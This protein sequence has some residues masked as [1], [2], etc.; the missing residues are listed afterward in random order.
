MTRLLNASAVRT[1]PMATAMALLWLLATAAA[2]SPAAWALSCIAP[3]PMDEAVVQAEIA[4]VGTVTAV[5]NDAHLASISVEEVWAG[6]DLPSVVEVGNV[7]PAGDPESVWDR[8]YTQ[9]VRYLFF[10][11]VEDGRLVDGPCTFTRE[12][13]P[14][15]EQY[16]PTSVRTPDEV[17]PERTDPLASLDG[18]AVPVAGIAIL[19]IVIIGGAMLVSR[20][21]G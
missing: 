18:L 15:L 16:R 3:P 6:P 20:R 12:W 8:S 4:F 11:Y 1:V 19:A 9:G 21:Q 7:R 2:H 14:E 5:A 10:P 17:A 13:Q